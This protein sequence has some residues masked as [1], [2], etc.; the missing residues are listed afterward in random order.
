MDT[1]AATQSARRAP[2]PRRRSP[3]LL[4]IALAAACAPA[5][6]QNIAT[7]GSLGQPARVLSGPSYDIPETLGRLAGGNLF[8]SFERFGLDSGERAHFTTATPSLQNVFARVTGGRLSRIAGSIELDAAAGSTPALFLMNPAGV[9][10]SDGASIDVPGAF[11]VTT[12]DSIRFPDGD[13]A[14]DPAR[15]SVMS[16]ASPEAFGFL[17]NR[18]GEIRVEDSAFV[19]AG[20]RDVEMVGGD[21]SVASGGL[22]QTGGGI[23]LVAFGAGA[24]EAGLSGPVPQATGE[25][26]VSGGGSMAAINLGSENARPIEIDGGRLRLE[27]ENS[28]I[29]SLAAEDGAA[30]DLIVRLGGPLSIAAGGRL[31]SAA[32]GSG[33]AGNLSVDA[34]SIVVDG[35]SSE[36]SSQTFG[37][38]R[39]GEVVLRS[40]GDIEILGGASIAAESFGAGDAGS[41]ALT[42]SNV[43]IEGGADADSTLTADAVLFGGD[44]GTID[45]SVSGDTVL[46]G[47]T[48]T[49]SITGPGSAGLI[50]LRTGRL[51]MEGG[52]GGLASIQTDANALSSGD[53]GGV[54]IAVAGDAELIDGALITSGND[55]S[56]EGGALLLS[57]ARLL[58]DGGTSGIAGIGTDA[59][60]FATGSG[61]DLAVAVEG[62]LR[63]LNSGAISSGTLGP[64]EAGSVSVVAGTLQMANGR[65]SSG[66][67]GSGSGGEVNVVVGGDA[68]LSNLS[69]VSSDTAGEGAAGT[70]GFRAGT[71][72]IDGGEARFARI[73]SS[74]NAGSTGDAGNVNVVVGGRSTIARGGEISSSTNGGGDAGSVRLTSGELRIEG[75]GLI[76]GIFSDANFEAEG[77]AGSVEVEI[78]GPAVLLS[79]ALIS[80]D[81]NGPG[82]AGSVLLRSASLEVDAAGFDE[83]GPTGVFSDA[84][85]SSSGNAGAVLVEVAGPTVLRSSAFISSDTDASGDAGQVQLASGSLDIAGGASI[86]GIFS[87]ANA[88]ATG[89]AG[90]VLVLIAGQTRVHDGGFISSSTFGPG[91]AGSVTLLSGQL[92]LGGAEGSQLAGITTLAGDASTGRGGE[93]LVQVGGQLRLSP[94]GLI[95]SDT[96][97]SGDAGSVALLAGELAMDGGTSGAVVSSNSGG[98]GAAGTVQVFAERALSI[99]NGFISSSAFS[100]GPAGTV[101]VRAP[102]LQVLAG[103]AIAAIA[104][105]DSAGQVGN[106]AVLADHLLILDGGSLSISNAAPSAGPGGVTPTTLLAAAP[107]I[108][109]RNGGAITAESFGAIPASEIQLLFGGLLRVDEARISTSA[110]DG[111]GGAI[112]V[113]GDGVLYLRDAAILTSVVGEQ[114]NGGDILIDAGA[115]TMDTGFI[116]ANTAATAAAGGNVRIVVGQVIPSAAQVSVGGDQAFDFLSAI[117]TKGFNVIQAAAPTGVSGEIRVTAAPTDVAGSLAELVLPAIDLGSFARD[118]C[119]VDERNTF[120]VSGRRVGRP[121]GAWPAA[122]PPAAGTGNGA[123]QFAALCHS[124][125][126]GQ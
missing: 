57:A 120:T 64:A 110:R 97:G 105:P 83:F 96:F 42:A 101:Q 79:G 89:S 21:L 48:M 52:I 20:D 108:L 93:V 7:D 1:I 88:G 91:N 99:A 84:N 72:L 102:L 90:A 14:A 5:L 95:V 87:D 106:V 126:A 71:L 10:F 34:A 63:I 74:A 103:G 59:G 24:G 28:S 30:G 94:G 68:V 77:D 12:A 11:H 70:V 6:A 53:A 109:I 118:P 43:R 56:G 125:E 44:A 16:S 122:A 17:G 38:G 116:Q 45:L 3:L 60:V 82:D 113:F 49:A 76:T 75:D 23:R 107:T 22:I 104:L 100:L 2:R 40:A 35:V 65:I 112:A 114:G 81:T 92:E 46:R 55:G 19:A 32:S 47:G 26:L 37:D 98:A 123:M 78:A 9:V 117:G 115:L 4:H 86:A 33:A 58:I 80:S 25:L 119:S 67:G 61:G 54:D 27:G 18:I 8:H 36:L 69:V 50:R 62:E 73:S 66:S 111:D 51:L 39:G 121:A 31:G 13:F 124:P 85:A 15:A 41:L 29:A